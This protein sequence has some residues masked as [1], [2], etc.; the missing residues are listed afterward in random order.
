ME[1]VP[2]EDGYKEKWDKFIEINAING[3]FLQSRRFLS[4]HKPGKFKDAS[5]IIQS[6]ATD[7]YAII[8]ASECEYE[9][10]KAFIS[11]PGSTFGGLV[12]NKSRN[13]LSDFS[14]IVD[15]FDNYLRENHFEYA[16]LKFTPDLFSRCDNTLLEYLMR[17]RGY[18]SY[19][20]L[21]TYI[22]YSGYNRHDIL[23]N[24][25]SNR[26]KM[27]RR[28]VRSNYDFK[29]IDSDE[30]TGTFYTLLKENLRKHDVEPVH[31]LDE[32]LNFKN[33][34]LTDIVN[35]F[36]LYE[37]DKMIAGAMTFNFAQR[38]ILHIQYSA[39]KQDMKD[40]SPMSV[41][42]YNL[43][44]YGSD[45]NFGYL[46]MGVSTEQRGSVLNFNLAQTKESYGSKFSLNRTFYRNLL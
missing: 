9:G 41:L 42:F 34:I 17:N 11:H 2:Y 27:M 20:E 10:K 13:N 23:S 44:A 5:I 45:A 8:P 37:N 4:Y 33:F 7:V 40:N 32:I 35:F 22:D 24:F 25:N 30:E 14:Q 19:I 21:S 43:I 15:Y 36:G 18:E 29:K 3:T 16:L 1:V 31:T 46:S 6:N 28:F 26:R 12:I 39:A 38:N